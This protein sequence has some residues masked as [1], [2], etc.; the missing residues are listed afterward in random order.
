MCSILAFFNIW[1]E[2]LSL[3]DF[4][5]AWPCMIARW[6]HWRHTRSHMPFFAVC[7]T[8]FP[9]EFRPRTLTIGL[10]GKGLIDQTNAYDFRV[11]FSFKTFVVK[12][13]QG[14]DFNQDQK[15]HDIVFIFISFY[16]LKNQSLTSPAPNMRES[17]EL[18]RRQCPH[19]Y[20]P[21]PPPTT[22][23]TTTTT[24]ITPNPTITAPHQC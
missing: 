24:T 5:L 15:C 6:H 20:L 22:T 7:L 14:H 12:P 19:P 13:F 10:Y 8:V 11:Q 18:A 3:Q 2:K 17:C 9:F 4:S 1:T 21:P 16:I 23:T